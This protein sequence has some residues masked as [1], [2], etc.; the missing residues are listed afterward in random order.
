MKTFQKFINKSTM[1]S[2]CVL[3]WRGNASRLSNALI[4]WISA[5]RNLIKYLFIFFGVIVLKFDL[6][7][8]VGSEMGGWPQDW[9]D[10]SHCFPAL[11][12][13]S[14]YVP[15]NSI[16]YNSIRFNLY[17]AITWLLQGS[18]QLPTR[19]WERGILIQF[20]VGI[21]HIIAISSFSAPMG[22][23]IMRS[24]SGK[25]KADKITI[26]SVA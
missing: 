8:N 18:S 4:V 9:W 11:C 13:P 16:L 3:E 23:S 19:Q 26:E 17:S 21:S 2:L 22:Y 15:H 1:S 14:I 5:N 24:E 10:T 20:P 6:N 12:V 7:W 25:E